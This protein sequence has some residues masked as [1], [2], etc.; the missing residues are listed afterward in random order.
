[1]TQTY[2]MMYILRPDLLEEQV[3]QQIERYQTFLQEQN[4]EE[5]QVK[6]LGKRRLAYPI[7]RH[8]EGFYVQMNYKCHGQQ[9]APIERAM[10][11]SDEV[12]RYLTIKLDTDQPLVTA[13]SD[14]GVS[15]KSFPRESKPVAAVDTPF[16]AATDDD[17]L[18]SA[19]E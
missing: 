8:S 5:I 11:L 12:I 19:E 18:Y 4:A 9:V 1:M 17:D 15:E 13:I 7:K 16:P 3:N 6:N 14:S 2:E 10:R